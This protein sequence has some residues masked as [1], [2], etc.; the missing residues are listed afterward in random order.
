MSR[1]RIVVRGGAREQPCL[2]ILPQRE[3]ASV[4]RLHDLVDRLLAEVRDRAELGFGLGDQVADRLDASALEAV[5][6]AHAKLQLLDQ[7]VPLLALHTAGSGAAARGQ[8][9]TVRAGDLAAGRGA[10]LLDA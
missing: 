5:V 4:Q 1:S 10:Q 7:D 9:L 8:A 2:S 6:G 3:P